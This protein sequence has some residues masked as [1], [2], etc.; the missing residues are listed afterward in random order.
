[1]PRWILFDRLVRRIFRRQL[2]RLLAGLDDNKG[3]FFAV[4][5]R[6]L[7]CSVCSEVMRLPPVKIPV[8]MDPKEHGQGIAFYVRY[9]NVHASCAVRHLLAHP[10]AEIF[11]PKRTTETKNDGKDS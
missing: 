8:A 1:M 3:F 11:N 4:E 9:Q 6:I 7:R 5:G 2:D 10:G